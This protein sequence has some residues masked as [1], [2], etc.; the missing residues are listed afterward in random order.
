MLFGSRLLG[1]CNA[2]SLCVFG[3]CS[4][5][6]VACGFWCLLFVVLIVLFG[7]DWCCLAACRFL[8]VLC[9]LWWLFWLRFKLVYVWV[10]MF[11]LDYLICELVVGLFMFVLFGFL[12]FGLWFNCLVC[13]LYCGLAGLVWAWLLWLLYVWLA[14]VCF[15][16]VCLLVPGAVGGLSVFCFIWWSVEF[17]EVECLICL[18]VCVLVIYVWLVEVIVIAYLFSFVVWFNLWVF[19]IV[20][21]WG[22]IYDLFWVFVE[23]IDCLACVRGVRICHLVCVTF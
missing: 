23:L 11:D 19:V 17:A 9:L 1:I 21:I 8:D 20:W 6:F 14:S 2:F 15:C 12:L 4:C 5:L 18:F 13:G 16:V 3:V 7:G 22:L 10:L